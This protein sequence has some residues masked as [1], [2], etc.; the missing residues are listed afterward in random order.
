M[1]DAPGSESL[2]EEPLIN[3]TGFFIYVQKSTGASAVPTLKLWRKEDSGVR[4]QEMGLHES[5]E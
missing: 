5:L 3:S 2:E 4:D 1:A